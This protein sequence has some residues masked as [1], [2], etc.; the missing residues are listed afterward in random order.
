MKG[1]PAYAAP[2]SPRAYRFEPRTPVV[3]VGTNSY[4]LSTTHPLPPDPTPAW[5]SDEHLRFLSALEQYGAQHMH[6]THQMQQQDEQTAAASSLAA[7]Q[8]IA[9][10]VRTR[11]LDDVKAHASWYLFELQ[12]VNVQ[13]RDEQMLLQAID[14]R[15]T[16]EEDALF[17]HLLAVHAGAA[18]ESA[19]FP[20]ELIAAK[21]PDKSPRDVQDRYHKLCYDIARIE[22]GRHVTMCLNGR[23]FIRTKAETDPEPAARAW[24]CV[25]T[26]TAEEE[27]LLAD[28]LQRTHAPPPSASSHLRAAL[29]SAVATL[30][31]PHNKIP[32]Q[33]ASA[34]FTLD[35]AHAVF[36]DLLRQQA[37]DEAK[38][39]SGDNQDH[40]QQRL[41]D[42]R[43]VLDVIV[44]RL[45]L[46]PLPRDSAD[47]EMRAARDDASSSSS[48]AGQQAQPLRPLATAGFAF[49]DAPSYSAVHVVGVDASA[50]ADASQRGAVAEDLLSFRKQPP[51]P[52]QQ[53]GLPPPP[54]T[55]VRDSQSLFAPASGGSFAFAYPPM[56]LLP[57]PS[58]SPPAMSPPEGETPT[59]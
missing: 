57:S 59:R 2:D 44:R 10:S 8:A 7:W 14:A 36:D 9:Q 25:V 42:P 17:E 6:H 12:L 30:T 26:L 32:P 15:W 33:R 41:V 43:A 22:A 1:A 24:D 56:M 52:M 23:R 53:V 37:Q 58:V 27:A 20:W 40:E 29:T 18:A 47:Q 55:R 13:R 49:G 5:T 39:G 11:T 38:R 34:L 28:A 54:Q 50:K 46:L 19:C 45:R 31:G 4:N 16:L 51:Q 3:S 21:L 35:E 48:L